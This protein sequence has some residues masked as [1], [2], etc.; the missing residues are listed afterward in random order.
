MKKIVI[1]LVTVGLFLTPSIYR[2]EAQTFTPEQQA[3]VDSLKQQLIEMLLQQ[4]AV[5]QAQ[6]TELNAQQEES[7]NEITKVSE[8]VEEIKEGGSPET[9]KVTVGEV[10]CTTRPAGQ[11]YT[12]PISVEGQWTSGLVQIEIPGITT[13]SH[14]PYRS[15]GYRSKAQL[16]EGFL[17]STKQFDSSPD[18]LKGT[19]KVAISN[20]QF[21]STGHGMIFPTG[22]V[23]QDVKG[24]FIMPDC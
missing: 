7:A 23:L 14:G 16:A 1:T 5:L 18:G 15:G 13:L 10:Q 19:Y 9:T 3:L 17:F 20:G 2:A 21:Y 6:I 22:S 12:L 24:Q 8:K 11:Y 4:I